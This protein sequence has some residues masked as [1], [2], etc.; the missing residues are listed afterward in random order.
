MDHEF[1][2]MEFLRKLPIPK[3]IK[4]RYPISDE[5]ARH[6]AARDEEIK[7]IFTGESDKFILIIG[8]CSADSEAPVMEYLYRLARVQEK[9]KD[10]ILMITRI[11]TNKPRTTSKGNK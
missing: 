9:V 10:R 2:Q 7:K 1:M 8:P 5:T 11:Y 6:K 4:A 3:E